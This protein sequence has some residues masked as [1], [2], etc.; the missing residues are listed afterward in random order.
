MGD[1]ANFV[2]FP[3]PGRRTPAQPFSRGQPPKKHNSPSRAAV[4]KGPSGSHT[5]ILRAGIAAPTG[6]LAGAPHSIRHDA[7][8]YPRTKSRG[9]DSSRRSAISSQASACCSEP[10]WIH[11]DTAH[12]TR[13]CSTLPDSRL[14]SRPP[15]LGLGQSRTAIASTSTRK[16]G[17]ARLLT[18]RKVLAGGSL[19]KYLAR[20]STITG[21]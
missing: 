3:T 11:L 13:S 9:K 7:N 2:N 4:P 15:L 10:G 18:T 5:M 1:V 17:S 16:P 19:G 12:T 8:C 14:T 6:S 21:R 20:I